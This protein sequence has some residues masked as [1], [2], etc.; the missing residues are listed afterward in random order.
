MAQS[1]DVVAPVPGLVA[2]IAAPVGAKVSAG[3][4][5]VTL[6]AM[7]SEIAVESDQAGTVTEVL[8][9]E[10]EEVEMGAVLARVRTA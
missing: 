4:A 5:V 6:Q 3:D 1:V 7:K 9:R 10:G 2:S 8:V